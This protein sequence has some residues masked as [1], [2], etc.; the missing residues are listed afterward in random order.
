MD[1]LL[2]KAASTVSCSGESSSSVSLVCI[3]PDLP[4]TCTL[5]ELLV[6]ISE[7]TLTN[8]YYNLKIDRHNLWRQASAFYKNSIYH[9]QF[10]SDG[11]SI[12]FTEEEGVDAGIMG[13]ICC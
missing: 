9:P 11:L 2:D 12:T 7:K 4:P 6:H 3:D 8:K 1:S 13:F 5:D 10:L